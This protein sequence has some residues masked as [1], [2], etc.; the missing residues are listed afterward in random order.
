MSLK[1]ALETKSSSIL[2]EAIRRKLYNDGVTSF[3]LE[4]NGLTPEDKAFVMK[5]VYVK[6]NGDNYSIT[7]KQPQD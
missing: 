3:L 1:S 4:V 2:A 6:Q 7:V 5:H